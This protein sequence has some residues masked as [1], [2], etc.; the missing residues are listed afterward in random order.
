MFVHEHSGGTRYENT[1]FHH[2]RYCR[3]YLVCF[4]YGKGVWS[5]INGSLQV[6]PQ[7][8]IK[9]MLLLFFRMQGDDGNIP[10]GVIR[11]NKAH[12]GYQYHRNQLAPGWAAHK[13][14][15]ET[16]LESSL[17]QAVHKYVL[18]TGDKGIL[19]FALSDKTILQRMELEG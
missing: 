14:T 17:I 8:T 10:D 5:F 4:T 7:D 12:G 6:L 16:D 3:F 15:V 13:N 19:F 9:D 11:E 2:S 1:F 18:A